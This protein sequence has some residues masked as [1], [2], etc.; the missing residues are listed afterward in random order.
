MVLKKKQYSFVD[1]ILKDLGDR[2]NDF[3]QI[4]T[5]DEMIKL[6]EGIIGLLEE[7]NFDVGKLRVAL[8]Q[9]KQDYI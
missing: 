3:S 6:F 9:L 1:N 8:T 5:A 7:K 2:V 4:D